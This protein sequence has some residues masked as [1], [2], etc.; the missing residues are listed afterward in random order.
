M[1]IAYPNPLKEKK[2]LSPTDFTVTQ[3]TMGTSSESLQGEALL[4][5]LTPS[6]RSLR[7]KG[8]EKATEGAKKISTPSL[9]EDG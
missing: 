5:Q 9:I 7:D 8:R 6:A 2:D 3:V 4:L 1:E